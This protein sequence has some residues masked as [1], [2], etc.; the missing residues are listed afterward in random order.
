LGVR[1][2]YISFL[3][4][5]IYFSDFRA[6][7]A[8]ARSLLAGQ[9]YGLDYVRPPLY[10]LFLAAVYWLFGPHFWAIRGVQALLGA[11]ATVFVYFLGRRVLGELAGR[12]AALI[13]AFYPYYIFIAGL[14]YPTLL[15][16]L[17]LILTAWFLLRAETGRSWLHVAAAALFLGLAALAVP[18]SLV[19][20]PFMIVWLVFVPRMKW[21]R[22]A[23]LALISAAVV[24]LTLTPWTWYNYQRFGQFVPIDARAAKHLPAFGEAAEEEAGEVESAGVSGRL[25]GIL[26]NP[27]PFLE[28]YSREFLHFWTFVPDRVVTQEE[29]YR[30]RIHQQDQRMVVDHSLTS[31]WLNYV[32]ILSYGPVFLLSLVGLA[33]GLAHWR[34]LSLILM[35]L[36]SQA[37]GYSFFFTQVRYRLPVE[38]CLM[39]FAGGGAAF[40]INKYLIRK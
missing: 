28:R 7:D 33:A 29:S 35:L 32:S 24:A 30:Q 14:D 8:A 1:L 16:T 13:A 40:L 36:L 19:F 9:G 23:G 31:S 20:L 12:F 6:Y 4:E 17:F 15:T 34:P 27:G 25:R 39:I 11:V 21:S 38:F 22:R 3:K 18:V 5:G 37:L 26:E 10:P 2:A